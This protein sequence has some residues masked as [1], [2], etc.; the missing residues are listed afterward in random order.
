MSWKKTAV[1]ISPA[2]TSPDLGWILADPILDVHEPGTNQHYER[3]SL[4]RLQSRNRFWANP[5]IGCDANDI[6]QH[7]R[8]LAWSTKHAQVDAV[9]TESRIEDCSERLQEHELINGS[10]FWTFQCFQVRDL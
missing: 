3:M 8:G 2:V 1:S 6:L 9:V 7:H 4:E 10:R 5:S